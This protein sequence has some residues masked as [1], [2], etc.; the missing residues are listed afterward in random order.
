MDTELEKCER[1][2]SWPNLKYPGIFLKGM[3]RTMNLP[4]SRFPGRHLNS[5]APR[6]LSSEQ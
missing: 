5:T 4:N 1:K 6:V 2:R 3:R